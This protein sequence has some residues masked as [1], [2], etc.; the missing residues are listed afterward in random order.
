MSSAPMFIFLIL[1]AQKRN[2]TAA[3]AKQPITLLVM[4]RFADR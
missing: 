4:M 2:A 3:M 1:L